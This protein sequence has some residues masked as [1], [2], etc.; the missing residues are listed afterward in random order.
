MVDTAYKRPPITEAVIGFNFSSPLSKK[1]L[2][3]LSRKLGKLY[4]NQQI[5]P[6][7]SFKVGITDINFEKAETSIEKEDTYRL[8]RENMTQIVVLSKSSF[9]FSQLAPY[10]GWDHFFNSFVI[11]WEIKSKA[12]GYR[13]VSRIGVRYINRIDIPFENELIEYENYLNIYPLLPKSFGH[14]DAYATQVSMPLSNIGC[15]LTINSAVVESPILNH[16][17]FV[18]DLDIF[19]DKNIPKIDTDIFNLLKEIRQEKNRLFEESITDNA[20]KLFNHE[21]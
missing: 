17:A 20:R 7:L 10:Q 11:T 6:N 14:L 15:Q 5:I 13:E 3:S 9:L 8:S 16:R 21:Q 18:I 2:S 4:P 1:E 19:N 12:I